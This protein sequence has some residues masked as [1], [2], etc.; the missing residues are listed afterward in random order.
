MRLLVRA[1][2]STGVIFKILKDWQVDDDTLSALESI[3][4]DDNASPE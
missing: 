1:G 3:D 2:F 4:T